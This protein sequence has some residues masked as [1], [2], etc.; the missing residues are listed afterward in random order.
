MPPRC[1]CLGNWWWL[2]D[3]PPQM[4]FGA[5]TA[6]CTASTEAIEAAEAALWFG[7][8][9]R[10]GSI[11]GGA[12]ISS[13]FVVMSSL[14]LWRCKNDCKEKWHFWTCAWN[15]KI[16]LAKI[17][18]LKHYENGNKKKHSQLVPGSAKSRTYAGKSTKRGFSKKGL[19]WIKFFFLF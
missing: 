6:D 3:C 19:G 14:L 13:C 16:F 15:S 9:P 5:T 2:D 17:V 7:F 4:L 1:C 10:D 12:A 11:G 18:L 8:R